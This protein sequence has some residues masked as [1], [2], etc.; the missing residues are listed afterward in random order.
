[1]VATDK[2]GNMYEPYLE[3]YF[4]SSDVKNSPII[5][6]FSVSALADLISNMKELNKKMAFE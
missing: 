2:H 5:L 6:E 3:L 4:K 1:M